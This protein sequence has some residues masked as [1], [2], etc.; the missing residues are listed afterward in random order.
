MDRRIAPADQGF[1][2]LELV[3]VVAVVALLSITAVFSVGRSAGPSQSDT[4][5]FKASYDR[6]RHAAIMSHK[7]RAMALRQKGFQELE[8]HFK[9]D[10]E[11]PWQPVNKAQRYGGEV[12]FQGLK[13]PLSA[14]FDEKEL[15]PDV[16]FLPD[17]QATPFDVSF[18]SAGLV[19]RCV[20]SGW[21]GLS[22]EGQ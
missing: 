8:Y 18:I 16:V 4:Q 12:R 5:R 6:L 21:S 3:I 1:T 13:D 17:G 9:D 20:G 7:P 15:L 22:C 10:G 11:S 2:L 14:D 19:T